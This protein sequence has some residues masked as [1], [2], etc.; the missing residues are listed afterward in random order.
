MPPVL[1]ATRSRRF[2]AACAVWGA[3]LAC[4]VGTSDAPAPVGARSPLPIVLV[5]IDTLNPDNLRVYD[6]RAEALPHLDAFARQAT[7]FRRAY[8]TASWTLPSH[9]SMLTGLYPD[10]HGATDPRRRIAQDARTLAEVLQDAG[11]ETAGFTDEGYVDAEFG[12]GRGFRIYNGA[13][14]GHGV[15]SGDLPRQGRPHENHGAALFDRA[16][17]FLEARP[18]DSRPLFLFVQTYSVH[19]YFKVRRETDGVDSTNR[20]ELARRFRA[21][22]GGSLQCSR[23]DWSVLER[24]Y[25]AE[26][27]HLDAAF[28]RL[29]G[30]LEAAGM[31]DAVVAL[32]SDHGEGFSPGRHRIHHGGRLHADVIRIPFLLR[33]PGVAAEIVDDPVSL[34]D[35]MPILLDRAGVAAPQGLDGRALEA[36]AESRSVFAMEHHFRW[37]RGRRVAERE[38]RTEPLET[39]VI[40]ESH[41]LIA[42]EAGTELY[43]MAA[44]ADQTLPAGLDAPAAAD[45]LQQVVR[46]VRP[47]TEDAGALPNAELRAQ[48]EAL[49]YTE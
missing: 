34:V 42:G 40:D 29:L 11:Y 38:S 12:F 26:V 15:G 4:D 23:E 27:A 20:Q 32:V 21:C 7:T 2:A 18:A 47:L 14:S 10:R 46:R 41:W 9:A 24:L 45:L 31:A 35:V 3:V 43:D 44:D 39:A 49:G 17:A 28:G 36:P 16:V 30:A 5:S 33:G 19:D 25:Q 48:L 22:I 13:S 1:L 37:E 8:S 6:A